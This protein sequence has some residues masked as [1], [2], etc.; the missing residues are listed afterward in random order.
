MS[1]ISFSVRFQFHFK[2]I[3]EKFSDKV[4]IDKVQVESKT[5]LALPHLTLINPFTK[6][7]K[8]AIFPQGSET[9]DLNVVTHVLKKRK[10]F[11]TLH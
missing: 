4:G 11:T 9:L 7:P 8:I 10:C 5:L 3:P 2:F 1:K 6:I